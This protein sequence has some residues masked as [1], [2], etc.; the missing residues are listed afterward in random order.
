M[1]FWLNEEGASELKIKHLVKITYG[2]FFPYML[3]IQKLA[4]SFHTNI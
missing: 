2:K 4:N 1:N 3:C